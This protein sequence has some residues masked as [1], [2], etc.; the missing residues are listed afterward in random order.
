MIRIPEF[1]MPD[2]CSNRVEKQIKDQQEKEDK[3]RIEVC[4]KTWFWFR[5]FVLIRG[6]CKG[7]GHSG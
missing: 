4:F 2:L 5:A 1:G 6:F 3:K 7:A